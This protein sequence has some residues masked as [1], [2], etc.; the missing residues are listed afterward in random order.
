MTWKI[1]TIFNNA[2]GRWMHDLMY[3]SDGINYHHYVTRLHS[4]KEPT[5]EILEY[6]E[7]K[8]KEFLLIQNH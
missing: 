3:S 2:L 6:F 7:T 1:D 4:D 8:K 5:A